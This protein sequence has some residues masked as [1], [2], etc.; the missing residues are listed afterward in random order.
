LLLLLLLLDTMVAQLGDE[1]H[2]RAARS[3]CKNRHIG[4]MPK[5]ACARP[6]VAEASPP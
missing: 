5:R 1:V 3:H 6:P 4:D 2:Y